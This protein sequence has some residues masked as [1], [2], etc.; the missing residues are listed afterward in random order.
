M[1]IRWT[2][3]VAQD[4][5]GISDYLAGT[6][7]VIPLACHTQAL[8]ENSVV[9]ADAA[10]EGELVEIRCVAQRRDQDFA[11]VFCSSLRCTLK[12]KAGS[13]KARHA[14]RSTRAII[15]A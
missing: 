1:R 13:D 7:S 10:F 5:L 15:M 2:P 14:M 12:V 11:G 3:P 6:L 4:M 8:P 9:E